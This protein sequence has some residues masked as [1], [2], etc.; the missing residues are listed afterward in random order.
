MA[1]TSQGAIARHQLGFIRAAIDATVNAGAINASDLVYWTGSGAASFGSGALSLG[2]ALF[3]NIAKMLGVSKDTN[4]LQG[5]IQNPLLDIGIYTFGEQP[6]NT[7]SGDTYTH[8]APVT[9]GTDAQ[10]IQLAPVGPTAATAGLFT[11]GTVSGGTLTAGAHVVT[12]SYLTVIGE[13]AVGTP[14]GAITATAGQG[15]IYDYDNAGAVVLPSWAIGFVVYVDGVFVQAF[16]VAPVADADMVGQNAS[17]PRPS[18]TENALAIGYAYMPLSSSTAGAQTASIAGG[19][20]V[21]LNVRLRQIYP[22][23]NGLI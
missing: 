5:G 8:L 14:S 15:L 21:T 18:P 9:I 2:A 1:T 20:G 6:F 16:Y 4:P 12:M 10:T 22:Q 13:T 23:H 17:N 11:A 7:T 3:A 19:A